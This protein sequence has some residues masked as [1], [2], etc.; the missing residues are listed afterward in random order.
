MSG[1]A[2]GA[3]PERVSFSQDGP[4]RVLDSLNP[5]CSFCVASLSD[6][7]DGGVRVKSRRE[8]RQDGRERIPRPPE[9]AVRGKR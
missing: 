9:E 1:Q 3:I 2:P 4:L 7:G 6:V 5:N 8:K